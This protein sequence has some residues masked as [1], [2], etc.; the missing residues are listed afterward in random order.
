MVY[1]NNL[2]YFARSNLIILMGK[3]KI[4]MEFM[5]KSGSGNI[6][7]NII[8]TA[9]GLETWFADRVTLNDKTFTFQWGKSEIKNALIVNYRVNSFIKM[10]WDDEEDPKAYFELRLAYNEL[11]KDYTLEVVDFAYPDEIE[12]QQELWTS[13]IDNLKRV[14]GL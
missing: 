1:I 14:S 4:H 13:Q 12:D 11:T 9:S 6:V 2:P 7:W 8:S 3:E 5:L 10:K